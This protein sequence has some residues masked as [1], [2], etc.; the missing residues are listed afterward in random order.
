MKTIPFLALLL[1]LTPSGCGSCEP[2][3]GAAKRPVNAEILDEINQANAWFHAKK[4]RPIWAKRLDKDSPI[5]LARLDQS[6]ANLGSDLFKGCWSLR[7]SQKTATHS[8]N[9]LPRSRHAA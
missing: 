5:K 8:A 1:I 7:P 2:K 6:G 9:R 3:A 4:I